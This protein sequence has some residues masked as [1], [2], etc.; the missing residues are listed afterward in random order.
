[1]D[2]SEKWKPIKGYEKRYEIS[3]LGRVKS[4]SRPKHIPNGEFRHS[5]EKVLKLGKTRTG[6]L[7]AF[8]YRDSNRSSIPVHRLVADAFINNPNRLEQVNHIDGDK[9]NNSVSNLEWCTGSENLKHATRILHRG[10]G[11]K[12]LQQNKNGDILR[13]WANAGEASE[14]LKISRFHIRQCVNGKRKSAG[15]FIWKRV[16]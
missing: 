11:E 16:V 5:T 12:I 15:G 4:L 8:L 13:H 3:S 10:H 2:T 6:Y 14:K 7:L 1:M 9:T